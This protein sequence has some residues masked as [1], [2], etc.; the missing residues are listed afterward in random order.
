[1]LAGGGRALDVRGRRVGVFAS[2]LDPDLEA[3]DTVGLAVP[4]TDL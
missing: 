2:L 3:L 4:R 1:M